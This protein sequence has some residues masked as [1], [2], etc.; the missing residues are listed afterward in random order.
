VLS[1]LTGKATLQVNFLWEF[2]VWSYSAC[3]DLLYK[4]SQYHKLRN[5]MLLAI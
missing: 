5:I 3:K 4:I 1:S 2:L